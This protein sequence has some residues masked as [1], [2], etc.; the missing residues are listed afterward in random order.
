M[1]HLAKAAKREGLAVL[2]VLTVLTVLAIA[3]C[4]ENFTA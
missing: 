4:S 2:T 3:C 1:N